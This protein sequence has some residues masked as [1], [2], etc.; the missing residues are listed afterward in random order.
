V[1]LA[2]IFE[3]LAVVESG[4]MSEI[5]GWAAHADSAA[6]SADLPFPLPDTFD[7]TP[8]EVTQSKLLTPYRALAAAVR[9]EERSFAFWTYVAAHAESR[10]V[11]QAAERMALEELGHISLLRRERRAAFHVDAGTSA[12]VGM[13]ASDL[14]DEERRIADLI[15][16]DANLFGTDRET[17]DTIIH[18]SREAASKLESFE[19]E[20][21]LRIPA[22]ALPAGLS[23]DALA[24]SE[25]LV[26]AYLALGDSTKDASIVNEV[27]GL[28]SAA[29]Y[30]L[31][32]LKSRSEAR[33]NG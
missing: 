22:P 8:E 19:E 20:H 17:A 31:A 9:H 11:R 1:H 12:S 27:Q 16:Q 15:E 7:A 21:H 6:I 18:A 24:M 10:E 14:A 3:R 25:R 29:I 32:V 23:A 2:E 33:F 13:G 5:T 28:A 30:R 4:H 26:E